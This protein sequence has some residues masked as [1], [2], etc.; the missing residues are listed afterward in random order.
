MRNCERITLSGIYYTVVSGVSAQWNRDSI[1]TR[2]CS[3]DCIGI[4]FCFVIL[5][6]IGCYSFKG[7][8]RRIKRVAGLRRSHS[9][10]TSKRNG[11]WIMLARIH[12]TVVRCISAKHDNHTMCTRYRSGNYH[13]FRL[14]LYPSHRYWCFCNDVAKCCS[15][16]T[17]SRW[18]SRKNRIFSAAVNKITDIT[19]NRPHYIRIQKNIFRYDFAIIIIRI[20]NEISR[21]PNTYGSNIRWNTQWWYCR[22]WHLSGEIL[23]HVGCHRSKRNWLRIERIAGFRGCNRIWTAMGNIKRICFSCIDYLT[24]R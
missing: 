14:R 1:G 17:G 16:R 21:L 2:Y 6:D 11:E 4:L 18:R 23:L 5:R 20:D 22:L 8:N 7:H 9:V 13:P 3:W 10:W 19:F 15:N 12:N 24:S